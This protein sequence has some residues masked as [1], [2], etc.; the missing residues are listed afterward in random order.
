MQRWRGRL[1]SLGRLATFPQRISEA[2]LALVLVY[3][4]LMIHRGRS[5]VRS[6]HIDQG[7]PLGGVVAG[8]GAS[9]KPAPGMPAR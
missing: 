2:D 4:S 5:V 8:R 1:Q 7:V 3:L 9:Q 6:L